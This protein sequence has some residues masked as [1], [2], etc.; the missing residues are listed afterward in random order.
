MERRP[1]TVFTVE[2]SSE[3]LLCGTEGF[4]A[5]EVGKGDKFSWPKVFDLPAS[6]YCSPQYVTMTDIDAQQ[7]ASPNPSIT[8]P[9]TKV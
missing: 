1:E 9:G 2:T 3:P 5:A 4:C 8:A 7:H 6:Q